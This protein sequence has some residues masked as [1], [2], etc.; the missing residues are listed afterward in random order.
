[1]DIGVKEARSQFSSL[2]DEVE[3]GHEVI[4]RRRGKEVARMVPATERRKY[5]PSLKRFRSLIHLKGEPL[6]VMVHRN[7]KEERY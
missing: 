1:M 6:S 3:K 2:L 7:R 5:L 4:I